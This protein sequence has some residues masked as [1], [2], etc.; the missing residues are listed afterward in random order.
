[1]SKVTVDISEFNRLAARLTGEEMDKAVVSAVRSG[2]QIIRRKTIRNFATGTAFKAFNVYKRGGSSKRLPLVRLTV[3]K[4]GK[5]ATVDILGDFRAKFFE[6]G[7]KSRY[8]KGRRITGLR[9]RGRRIYLTRK[10]KPG[11]RGVISER[12]YFR[13]A[14]DSEESRVLGDMQNRVMKAVIK[15]GKKK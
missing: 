2:G 9:R 11:Y 8:T 1:M 13:K 4:R 5:S 14:Q 10:G 7:T 3:N 6:L 12:R 15:I